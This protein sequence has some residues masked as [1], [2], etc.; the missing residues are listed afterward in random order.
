M[1]SGEFQR[2]RLYVNETLFLELTIQSIFGRRISWSPLL[3]TVPVRLLNRFSA[4]ATALLVGEMPRDVSVVCSEALSG[5]KMALGVAELATAG[6]GRSCWSALKNQKSRSLIIRP[7]IPP[8][9][10]CRLS[11]GRNGVA[12]DCIRCVAV[13]GVPTCA[14]PI[15][16][17]IHGQAFWF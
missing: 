11:S 8:P 9:N 1:P 16:N 12:E 4:P 7:P 6:K 10:W 15:S 2:S 13:T 17:Q 3:G 5:A 14:L